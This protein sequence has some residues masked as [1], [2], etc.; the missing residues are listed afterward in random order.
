MIWMA[1]SKSF[2]AKNRDCI[3]LVD[4]VVRGTVCKE[5]MSYFDKRHQSNYFFNI[6]IYVWMHAMVNELLSLIVA[7]HDNSWTEAVDAR[8]L[9]VKLGFDSGTCNLVVV[10]TVSSTNS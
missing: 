1:D 2:N 10:H 5:I 6:K 4:E 7:D 9:L 8:L 3:V